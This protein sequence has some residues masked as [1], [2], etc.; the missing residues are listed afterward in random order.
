MVTAR[1]PD[2]KTV[3]SVPRTEIG[4]L[5]RTMEILHAVESGARSFTDVVEATSL[6][7][8]TAHRLLQSMEQHGLVT[9]VGG[10]GYRLGT[11]LLSL[12]GAASR[13]L[14]LRDIAQPILERLARTTGESAQLFV[15]DHERRRCIAAAQSDS[16]LRAIVEIGSTFPLT[17]GSAGKVFLAYG[18]PGLVEDQI[19]SAPAFTPKTPTGEQLERQVAA[20]RRQGWASSA[21]EREPGVGSV[22][23]P[24]FGPLGV[25][26]AVVSL[27]G[28]ERRIGRISAKRYAPA[29]ID[30][31][32]E[33]ERALGG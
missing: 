29:V 14:P 3:R 15:L 8:S 5:D 21:G 26:I 12:S 31:A 27:S 20:T 33:I 23:A 28:P 18:P 30:A 9:Y 4:V 24:V 25:V 10:Q 7:R 19:A 32:K 11:R 1:A 6:P 13:E 16:E 2:R 17:A 22:S